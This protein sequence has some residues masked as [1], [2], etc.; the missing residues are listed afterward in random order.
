MDETK[1]FRLDAAIEFEARDIDEAFV[2]L[3]AHFMAMYLSQDSKLIRRGYIELE[4]KP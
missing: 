3:A 4:P 1:T 2:L